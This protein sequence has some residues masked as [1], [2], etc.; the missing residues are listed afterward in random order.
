MRRSHLLVRY[1]CLGLLLAV[2][3][4][5]S[6]IGSVE[7]V[8]ERD[9]PVSV[10]LDWE[11]RRVGSVIRVAL[12]P[13]ESVDSHTEH[14]FD[15][16]RLRVDVTLP[17]GRLERFSIPK[18]AFPP[19]LI[20]GSSL[21]ENWRLAVSDRGVEVRKPTFQKSTASDVLGILLALSLCGLI[22]LA[23]V[24]GMVQI[25]RKRKLARE[26]QLDRRSG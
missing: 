18:S 8:N 12:A 26:R 7:I 9:Y 22:P 10:K 20:T 23:L 1:V 2:I 5:C 16:D 24:A 6:G 13:G 3:L 19:G 11:P 15:P 4:N 25:F 21:S 17:D 14:R